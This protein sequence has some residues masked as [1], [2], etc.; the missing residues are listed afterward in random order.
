M[1]RG[2]VFGFLLG[3]CAA[4]WALAVIELYRAW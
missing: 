2:L 3:F 4:V 1:R